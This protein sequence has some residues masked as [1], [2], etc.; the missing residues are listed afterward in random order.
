M[1]ICIV[2]MLISI[3]ILGIS[4]QTYADMWS[5]EE[6]GVVYFTNIPP[7]KGDAKKWR[8]LYKN[9]PGKAMVTSGTGGTSGCRAS[10]ADV[11]PAKDKS[12]ERYHRYDAYIAE[13]ARAYALPEALLRAVMATESD[14]DPYVVSCAGAKGLM[15][16]MP[17]EEKENLITNVFD[18]RRNIL[19]AARILRKRANQFQGDVAL[20]IAAYHAGPGAVRKYRGIPPY[21]TT[22]KYVQW[23]LKRYYR[24]RRNN[25]KV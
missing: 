22:Q 5:H 13:A 21:E 12:K 4:L 25:N 6:N 20:T 16:I 15:Q 7:K 11:I 17:E 10:R 3:S 9:G 24:F 2:W 19:G 23:V 1:R 8:A 18:P 14:Y